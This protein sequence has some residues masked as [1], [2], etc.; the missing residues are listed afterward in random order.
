MSS[1]PPAFSIGQIVVLPWAA[2]ALAVVQ[3]ITAAA[4]LMLAGDISVDVER[5]CITVAVQGEPTEYGAWR[6]I[7]PQMSVKAWWVEY[8][9]VPSVSIT[10]AP[11]PPWWA[12]LQTGAHVRV[13]AAAIPL[14]SGPD[15]AQRIART[16]PAG[17][18][19][20][21]WAPARADG[22]LDVFKGALW[23]R[24]EDVGPAQ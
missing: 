1:A 2:D 16:A 8:V 5:Q 10:P 23:V 19:L 17:A 14:Y 11:A 15:L 18:E 4:Q 3:A 21:L 9:Q 13:G 12:G 22:W 7:A 20:T 24:A 6:R